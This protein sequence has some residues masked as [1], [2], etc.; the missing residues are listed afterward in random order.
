M[1]HSRGFPRMRLLQA[2]LSEESVT[3]RALAV[4]D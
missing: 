1:Q 3:P 4:S 2:L